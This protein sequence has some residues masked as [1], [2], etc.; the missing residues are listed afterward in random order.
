MGELHI[1]VVRSRILTEYKIDAD[2]GPLQI[3]YKETIDSELEE[4][5]ETEK[6]IAGSKQHIRICMS[7]LKDTG[8]IFM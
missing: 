4:T 7:L 3:A 2:L 8:E 1:E 5:L 6:E